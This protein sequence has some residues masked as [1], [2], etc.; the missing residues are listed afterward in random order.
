VPKKKTPAAVKEI[1]L[2]VEKIEEPAEEPT[3][4]EKPQIKKEIK[5]PTLPSK[6]YQSNSKR[7]ENRDYTIDEALELAKELAT[8]KFDET[9]EVHLSLGIDPS[10]SSQQVRGSVKLP[11][12]TG[13]K[14]RVLVFAQ[15]PVAAKAKSAGATIADEAVFTAT[16]KG[17][18]PYDLVLATPEEMPKIA[19]LAK[20][21]GVRGL[22]PNPKTGTITPDPSQA[23][24]DRGSGLVDFRTT[25]SPTL[26]LGIGKASFKTEHLKENLTSFYLAVLA[27]KP[28]KISGQYLRS[29]ALS[30]TMGPSIK[31]DLD[32]LTSSS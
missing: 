19:K 32:T 24:S 11:H 9:I 5:R 6:R 4:Q 26:H 28:G 22:M 25:S 27:A 29:A 8:A 30:S 14:V 1:E 31:I 13:K 3:V 20:V 18:V 16:L 17:A 10:Q 21:L 12:G 2:E 15:G 7:V 23:I